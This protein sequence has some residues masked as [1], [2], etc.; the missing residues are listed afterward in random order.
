MSAMEI[1]VTPAEDAPLVSEPRDDSRH[2][3]DS[4]SSPPPTVRSNNSYVGIRSSVFLD[5]HSPMEVSTSVV[6]SFCRKSVL[7][8]YFRLL[9]LV[10]WRPLVETGER[11]SCQTPLRAFNVT[12]NLVISVVLILGHVLQYASCYRR[13]GIINYRSQ[14]S[15]SSSLKDHGWVQNTDVTCGGSWFAVYILPAAMQIIAYIVA[16]TH[17]RSHESE[18]FQA[19]L[20]KVFLQLTVTDVW[21]VAKKRI[22]RRLHAV[23][24]AG[25]LW[26]VA[27]L[28]SQVLNIYAGGPLNFERIHVAE[29]DRSVHYFLLM[30]LV[31]MLLFHDIVSM[32]IATSYAIHCQLV[33]V[34]LQNMSQAIREKRITFLEFFKGVEEA[35]KSVKY[36]NQRQAL[37]VTLQLT[38]VASRTVLCFYALLGTP[39]RQWGRFLAAWLN[40]FVWLSLVLI[41]L[42]QAS[43]LSST[44]NHVREVGL[45]LMAR[46]FG[47]GSAP[48]SELDTFLLF[49]SSLRMQAKLCALPITKRTVIFVF[50]LIGLCLF[51]SVQLDVVHFKP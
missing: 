27:S 8:H 47:Y 1:V 6:L 15:Q 39:W 38:W 4:S 34:Y 20:E 45:E 9:S 36:L 10:G 13:D 31:L 44:C 51:I 41:P 3:S 25:I 7:R 11:E 22:T 29:D 14:E 49:T 43:R 5:M 17:M 32:T 37:G 46:P 35:R 19:L 16:L 48:Q 40:V 18:Q 26:I 2:S 24:A 50:L 21:N 12:Y 33:L 30:S 28:A 42:V 23:Y